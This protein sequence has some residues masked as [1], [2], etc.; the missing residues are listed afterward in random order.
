VHPDHPLELALERLKKNPG[1][2]PVLS[3]NQVHRVEGVITP[4][5]LMEFLQRVWKQ[6]GSET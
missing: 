1:L 5:S 6:D 3:R 2:L 4:D